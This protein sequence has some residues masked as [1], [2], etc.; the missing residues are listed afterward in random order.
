MELFPLLAHSGHGRFAKCLLLAESG[1]RPSNVMEH[2]FDRV[3]RFA[4]KAG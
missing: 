2:L 1:H 4:T 3:V